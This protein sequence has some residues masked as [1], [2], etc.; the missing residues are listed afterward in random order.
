MSVSPDGTKIASTSKAGILFV[1]DSSTGRQLGGFK[2]AAP[3]LSYLLESPEKNGQL[4]LMEI[5]DN[6]RI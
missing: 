4:S 2:V 3:C 5:S 1:N 6:T